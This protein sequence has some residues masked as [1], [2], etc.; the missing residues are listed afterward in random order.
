M[1]KN[2][3]SFVS[4]PLLAIA[5]RPVESNRRSALNS[6]STLMVLLLPLPLFFGSPNCCMKSE[7]TRKNSRPL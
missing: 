5:S 6:S 4:G 3:Q 1:M 7:M 2:W